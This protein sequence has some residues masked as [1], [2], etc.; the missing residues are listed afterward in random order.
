MRGRTGLAAASILLLFIFLILARL[1]PNTHLFD[2]RYFKFETSF[3][4]VSII[5]LGLGAF[6]M[7]LFF[8]GLSPI[9]SRQSTVQ[10]TAQLDKVEISDLATSAQ[11]A[12]EAGDIG[13]ALALIAEITPDHPDHWLA[14]K[15]AADIAVF[16]G[17]NL[18]AE[19]LYQQSIRD[20]SG[21]KKIPALFALAELCEEEGRSEEAEELY[22]RV[23]RILP[24]A[25]GA[26]LRLRSIAISNEKWGQALG[27][28]EALERESQTDSEDSEQRLMEGAGIRCELALSELER[29]SIKTAS[30][31]MK[32]VSRMTDSYP[33][34][35]LV[36]G[37]I[38][39]KASGPTA[40]FRIWDRGF[41]ETF[42]PV[43]LTRIGE[44]FLSGGLPEDAIEYYQNAARLRA[45][46]PAIQYCLAELHARL[47]M[48]REAI[49]LFENVWRN[50]PEWPVA[51]KALADL[52]RKSGQDEK[53]AVLLA[54]IVDSQSIVLQW[55]CYNCSIAYNEYQGYC[56][57]C[58]RWNTIR[59]NLE[60]AGFGVEDA[61]SPSA[62]IRY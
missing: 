46:D 53:A 57:E 15:I 55:Q 62:V 4:F 1:D 61:K 54:Q 51:A 56:V 52:Y 14:K 20:G 50:N 22:K 39:Q 5:V 47:E 32:H 37:E 31:L 12:L 48:N 11:I 27:W 2:L 30:A 33:Q 9:R 38:Q 16:S 60:Q 8:A 24:G 17:S 3:Y 58:S 40:G 18:K 6:I 35:Y 42:S 13:R 28:Q 36:S 45:D 19:Q 43:L 25:T 44:Y 23:L 59:F 49:K 34:A 7:F 26:I 10:V 29:G 41:R 21:E